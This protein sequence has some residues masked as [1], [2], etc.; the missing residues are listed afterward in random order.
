MLSPIL[1]KFIALTESDIIYVNLGGQPVIILNTLEANLEILE[2]RSAIYSSRLAHAHS[3][4]RS[5]L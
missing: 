1:I 4:A 2:K 5:D 3:R